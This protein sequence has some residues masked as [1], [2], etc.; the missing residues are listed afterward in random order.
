MQLCRSGTRVLLKLRLRLGTGSSTSEELESYVVKQA[1]QR[2]DTA[3]LFE[4]RYVALYDRIS[5]RTMRVVEREF[6]KTPELICGGLLL[7]ENAA[8]KYECGEDEYRLG[9]LDQYPNNKHMVLMGKRYMDNIFK[10]FIDLHLD[11]CVVVES[12]HPQ[13]P[14]LR[15]TSVATSAATRLTSVSTNAATRPTSVAISIVT[16]F[17]V[18]A[19]SVATNVTICSW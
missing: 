9:V 5:K 8:D 3:R 12:E 7:G 4:G 14:T 2:V 13:H 10:R 11:E 6:E 15:Q 1:Q 19:I 17:A 18:G 16:S